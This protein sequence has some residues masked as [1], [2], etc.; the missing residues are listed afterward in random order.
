MV[1]YLT[2]FFGTDHLDLAEMVVQEALLRA[3]QNWPLQGIPDNPEAWILRAAKNAAIDHF[4]KKREDLLDP[5]DFDRLADGLEDN[6]AQLVQSMQKELKDDD[7][8][9]LFIC[10]HPVLNSETRVA[11]TLKTVCG[12]SV[13]EVARAFV[14]KEETIAQR[15]VRAKKKIAD[16]KIKY[17]VPNPEELGERMDSVLEVLYLLFNEGYLATEGNTLIRKDLCDEAIYRT[18]LLSE[19]EI[20]NHPQ[21]F[22]LLA[23][24]HF[25]ASRFQARTNSEGELLLLEDQD[26]S[27]WDQNHIKLGVKY[28]DQSAE[29]EDLTDYDLEAGIASYHAM[30]PTF[31]ETNWAG[32]LSLYEV[33]EI[34]TE[35]PI[36][37]LNKAVALGM[38]H[39]YP[40]GI[41]EILRIRKLGLLSNYYLL[42]AAL[43]EFYRRDGQFGNSLIYYNE[44]LKL[45]GTIPEKRLIEKRIKSCKENID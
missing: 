20:G 35:S 9:L 1:A 45:V 32:I 44:A 5:Q 36:V 21:V 10:C 11:L 31:A 16:E 23:L 15:L 24:M 19:H 13:K 14:A 29:G 43:A 42:P 30:A 40:A 39:G 6:D 27:L 3:V 33:L 18:T 22:A 17:E 25:Q 38:V 2:R 28:L 26:R 41:T 8:K 7:L 34:G 12:F 4:R 37:A